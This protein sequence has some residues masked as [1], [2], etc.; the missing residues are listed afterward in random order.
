MVCG[1]GALFQPGQTLLL[2]AAQPQAH[3]VARARDGAQGGAVA[4]T[5]GAEHHRVA[6]GEFGVLA[7]HDFL[8][9]MGQGI[10][11]SA[12]LGVNPRG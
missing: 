10:R 2:V 9:A 1:P 12:R 11:R 5:Q 7:G 8:V 4:L 3:G 6:D